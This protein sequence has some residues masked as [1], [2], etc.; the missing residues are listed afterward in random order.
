MTLVLLCSDSTGHWLVAPHTNLICDFVFPPPPVKFCRHLDTSLTF[1]CNSVILFQL[2]F[3]T[4]VQVLAIYII[5][6][7]NI[8]STAAVDI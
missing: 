8:L 5:Y 6:N 3:F 1:S 7:S 4:K 2:F